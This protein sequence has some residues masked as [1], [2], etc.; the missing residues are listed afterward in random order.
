MKFQFQHPKTGEI[1]EVELSDAQIRTEMEDTARDQVTCDCEPEGET[2]VVECNCCE[3]Y[4]EFVLLQPG[5][6]PLVSTEGYPNDLPA[7]F[8]VFLHTLFKQ[9]AQRETLPNARDSRNSTISGY[10]AVERVNILHEINRLRAL[11]KLAPVTLADVEMAW[12]ITTGHIE[13][14]SK[15]SRCASELAQEGQLSASYH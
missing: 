1:R 4:D 5:D 12:Y 3:Y 11:R 13:Y 9:R 10:V 2:N 6:T 14:V 15:L 7:H 8:I